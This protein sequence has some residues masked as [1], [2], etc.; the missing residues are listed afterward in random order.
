[1]TVAGVKVAFGAR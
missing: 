1:V